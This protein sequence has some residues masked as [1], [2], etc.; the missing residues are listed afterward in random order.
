MFS[1]AV[2]VVPWLAHDEKPPALCDGNFGTLISVSS[3]FLISCTFGGYG[4]HIPRQLSHWLRAWS[5]AQVWMKESL[6]RYPGGV[7]TRLKDIQYC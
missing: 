4:S 2:L 3:F 7:V 1:Q 6:V 5:A